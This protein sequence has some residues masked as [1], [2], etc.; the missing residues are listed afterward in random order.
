MLD[1]QNNYIE[2][3]SVIKAVKD[4]DILNQFACPI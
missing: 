2:R 1:H 3:S 4:L